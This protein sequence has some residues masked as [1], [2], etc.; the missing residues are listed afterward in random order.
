MTPAQLIREA[1]ERLRQA[2]V[3]DARVDTSLLLA[4]VTG[5]QALALRLDTDT[6]LDEKEL[7]AFERLC[8]RR[9]AREPL[10]YIL[11]EQPF[12]GRPFRVTPAVLIPRPETELLCELALERLRSQASPAVLDLCCGSGCIG[13]T[14]ALER[15]DA[16][17]TAADI[18]PEALAVARANADSLGARVTFARGDLF[19]AVEGQ[20]FDLIL[21]N[22][23]YIPTADLAPEA[24]QAEVQREPRLA[25]DGGA[26]GLSLYRRIAAEAPAHL[27]DGGLLLMELGIGE[28]EAVGELCREAG[29]T[30]VRVHPDLNGI[31]RMLEAR[32][33]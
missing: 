20:R 5:R 23:P 13:V 26:D 28:A 19:A 27:A 18:S 29:L 21:S 14:L 11:G 10:Q 16:R 32:F 31:P 6:V 15:P 3:P 1:A 8:A 25:L 17:V 33:C 9:A 4:H 24:L 7:D 2:G 30:D 22:P 12:F